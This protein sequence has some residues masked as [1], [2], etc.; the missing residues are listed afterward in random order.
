MQELWLQLIK[1]LC[2][3]KSARHTPD[4]VNLDYSIAGGRRLYNVKFLFAGV[5]NRLPAHSGHSLQFSQLHA[6]SQSS[7]F[8]HRGRQKSEANFVVFADGV[9]VNPTGK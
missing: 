8:W 4:C 3:G 7:F 6:A 9:P 5:N 2:N 1:G